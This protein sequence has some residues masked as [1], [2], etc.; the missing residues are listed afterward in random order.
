V[1]GVTTAATLWSVTVIGLCFGGGQAG[2]ALAATALALLTLSAL[3]WLDVRIPREHR[4]VL[5]IKVASG[6][7]P[8]SLT[9]LVGPLGYQARFREQKEDEAAGLIRLGYEVRWRRPEISG[10]PLNLLAIVGERYRIA[11]F[12]LT[13]ESP[14]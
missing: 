11:S 4:A 9:E 12:E 3:K 2:L 1:T 13:A 5:V 10:P 6:A 7:S 14:E 8:S